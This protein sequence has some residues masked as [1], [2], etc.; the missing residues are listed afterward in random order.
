MGFDI[1]SEDWDIVRQSSREIHA[2]VDLLDSG[3]KTVGELEG[4]IISDSYSVDASSD[5]RRTY[6]FEM[7]LR[8]GTAFAESYNLWVDKMIRLRIGLKHNVSCNIRWYDMGLYL[9]KNGTY[10]YDASTNTMSLSCLDLMCRHTGDRGGQISGSGGMIAGAGDDRRESLVNFLSGWCG[11]SKYMLQDINGQN[12]GE[13]VLP[14]NIEYSCGDTEVSV[15][16]KF[17]DINVGMEFFYDG[18]RFIMRR[19]PTMTSDPIIVGAD[20][21]RPMIVSIS[22]T[23]DYQSIHNVTEVWGSSRES[24]SD[25]LTSSAIV[26]LMSREPTQEEIERDLLVEPTENIDYVIDAE[27]PYCV[28]KIGE[29]RQVLSGG[30]YDNITTDDLAMQRAK[31]ENWRST[32]LLDR[33]SVVMVDIPWLDVNEKIEIPIQ[34]TVG[35]YVVK[36]K[37]GSSSE[38]TMTIQCV[39][40]QPIYSWL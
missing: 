7:C 18:D 14:D 32:D 19:Y 3:F 28:D 33:I 15:M 34:D 35:T 13:D 26:K 23:F 24:G 8:S 37:S 27:S 4:D 6:Q 16:T 5:V 20:I 1:Q 31:Y 22:K 11:I 25:I 9:V 17:R 39:R 2:E 40:F 12:S 21:I 10:Q 29:Y 30:E 36:Q 38:G